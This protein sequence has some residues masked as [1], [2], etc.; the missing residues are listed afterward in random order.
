MAEAGRFVPRQTLADA[1]LTGTRMAD[2]QGAAGAIKIVQ[3]VIVN[4]KPKVLEIIYRESDN[5]ILH[6]L[7]K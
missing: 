4:G 2:P 5:T 6:F 7:Y 1:I 3:N